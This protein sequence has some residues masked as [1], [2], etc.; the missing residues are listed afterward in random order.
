[1]QIMNN[2]PRVVIRLI[3]GPAHDFLMSVPL[4]RVPPFVAVG[5]GHPVASYYPDP[6]Q[7]DV[8]LYRYAPDVM[9]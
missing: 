3:G 4:D 7:T 6:G 5:A 1:M 8:R 2:D 9:N